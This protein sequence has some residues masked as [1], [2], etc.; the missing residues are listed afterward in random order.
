M[1]FFWGPYRIWPVAITSLAITESEYDTLLIPDPR[2]GD[3]GLSILTPTHL[4]GETLAL[5]AYKY[6]QGVREVM[7]ALNLANAAQIG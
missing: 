3:R 6:S 5:G 7:A 1:L 2:R 4:S